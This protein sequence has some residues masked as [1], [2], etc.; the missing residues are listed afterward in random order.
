MLLSINILLNL[1]RRYL[2]V[3]NFSEAEAIKL[4]QIKNAKD[5]EEEDYKGNPNLLEI[6]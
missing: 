4:E 5:D 1:F 2:F 3:D 6:L